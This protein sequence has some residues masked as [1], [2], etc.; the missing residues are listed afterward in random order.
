[1]KRM[2]TFFIYFLLLLGLY[3]VSNLLQHGLILN[4]YSTI[5]GNA[6]SNNQLNIE[7]SKV[8]ATNV[9]G[10][11]DFSI[12]NDS[13]DY[14]EKAY[15]KIDFIDKYD[16]NSITQYAIINDLEPGQT[17][18]Y[19]I[20]FRGNKIKEYNISFVPELPDK[21]HIINILGWE[22]DA[23]NV[24]GLGIDLTNIN[25]V[26]ITQYFS[27]KELK[28]LFSDS[29]SLGINFAKSIPLWGYVVA[30]LIVLWYI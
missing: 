23:T 19:K 17:R 22:I 2:K 7:V 27:I 20:N 9:N 18:N 5:E 11:M 16:L 12:T 26:D 6:E 24:F 1:M 28:N 4:M 13:N 8:K 3:I 30:S 25:G 29:W 14:I 21:T 15:A 10:Y